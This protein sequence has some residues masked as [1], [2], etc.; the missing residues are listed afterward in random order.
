MM[1]LPY[2]RNFLMTELLFYIV[3]YGTGSGNTRGKAD[4]I[5]KKAEYLL[6][7]LGV[8]DNLFYVLYE[9]LCSYIYKKNDF[10]LMYKI[11]F[12]NQNN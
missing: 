9:L 1:T 2:L 12:I 5:K 7:V 10:F 11:N 3:R 4:N 6:C 8:F